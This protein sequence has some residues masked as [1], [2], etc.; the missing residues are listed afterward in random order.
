MP[1]FISHA[2]PSHE[3]TP[4]LV[5]TNS[6]LAARHMIDQA[7]NLDEIL[8]DINDG[9]IEETESAISKHLLSGCA[10]YLGDCRE[11]CKKVEPELNQ[12]ASPIL[13][14]MEADAISIED[15]FYRHFEIEMEAAQALATKDLL[16]IDPDMLII[17]MHSLDDH[18][19][20]EY[21]L[22]DFLAAVRERDGTVTMLDGVSIGFYNVNMA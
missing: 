14:L 9:A 6:I 3:D 18:T 19:I 2:C 8:T 12:Y 15:D 5:F 21:Y 4:A 20:H 13:R 22:S 16:E 17:S 1:L 10:V 7:E 11:V